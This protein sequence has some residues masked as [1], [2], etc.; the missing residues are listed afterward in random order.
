MKSF[1]ASLGKSQKNKLARFATTLIATLALTG[2][3][4]AANATNAETSIPQEITSTSVQL[5]Q[6]QPNIAQ[7]QISRTQYQA[8]GVD[9]FVLIPVVLLGGL[10]IFVPL[11]FGGLVVIGEREVGIVVKKFTI[12]GKGL[13]AGQLIALNGEAGLQADTLAP[14]WH[15]GYWP[16]QYSVRKENVVDCGC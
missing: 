16:W 3:I 9:P 11:F 12:A 1:S 4:H 14:G 8:A 15:W 7:V 6:T 10:V 13:P 5:K 2:G